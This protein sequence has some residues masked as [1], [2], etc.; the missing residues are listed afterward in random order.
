MIGEILLATR[1]MGCAPFSGMNAN[2]TPSFV[3]DTIDGKA[4]FDHGR[5]TFAFF[6]D[7]VAI[8]EAGADA[9]TA[10]T[11]FKIKRQHV[12]CLYCARGSQARADGFA[13]PGKTG[14]V[15]KPN[16]ADYNNMRKVLKRAIDFHRR[17]ALC[18]S[19]RDHR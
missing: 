12:C 9:R 11:S 19:Q 17:A 18:R 3:N 5:N 7:S 8:Q 14:E 6:V 2:S 1:A 16:A 13:S 10:S 15:M 4:W